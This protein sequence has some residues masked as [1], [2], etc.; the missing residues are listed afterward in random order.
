MSQ[1]MPRRPPRVPHVGAPVVAA[2]GRLPVSTGRARLPPIRLIAQFT[3]VGEIPTCSEPL[4][5]AISA[6]VLQLGGA[7]LVVPDDLV[8]IEDVY[9][10][11]IEFRDAIADVVEKKTELLIVIGGDHLPG[12]TPLRL[13]VTGVQ[14]VVG[15][16]RARR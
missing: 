1:P 8:K 7:A 10:A 13:L 14:F 12:C 11:G 5:A 2:A 9:L 16:H 15:C 6:E 4:T 3:E